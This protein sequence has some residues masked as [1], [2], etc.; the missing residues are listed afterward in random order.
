MKGNTQHRKPSTL[1]QKYFLYL[2]E[3]GFISAL[4]KVLRFVTSKFRAADPVHERRVLLARQ[5]D[6]LFGSVVRYGPFRGLKLMTDSWWGSND[7]AGVLLGIYEQELLLSLQNIPPRYRTFVDLGAADGYYG[8]GVLIN[9]M[10]DNSH[11]FEISAIGRKIIQRNADLNGVSERVKIH[12]LAESDFYKHFSSGELTRTVLFVDIEGGEFDLF[13]K[14][15]LSEFSQSIIFIELH[16][17]YFKDGR[18]KLQRLTDD[19]KSFFSITELTTTSRDLSQ[20]S[21]LRRFSD[22]DRWLICSEGRG[23]L[24]T[25]LRLD[26]LSNQS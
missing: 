12:G 17:W 16:D 15:C 6:E 20:F 24:M 23:Q 13:S 11:C 26:P 18:E 9:K 22:T 2:S 3:E 4:K 21:E 5:I 19:A 10:F 25:W 7:R 14:K 1:A 8:V